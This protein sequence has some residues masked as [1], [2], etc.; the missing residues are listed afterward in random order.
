MREL[1]GMDG[2]TRLV[3]D[4]QDIIIDEYEKS[5]GKL[6]FSKFDFAKIEQRLMS[7]QWMRQGGM[8]G[9]VDYKDKLQEAINKELVSGLDKV[10]DGEL[11]KILAGRAA[12]STPKIIGTPVPSND[13]KEFVDFVMKRSRTNGVA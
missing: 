6:N 3:I 9:L 4:E 12:A 7:E 13:V 10:I 5:M 2:I 1:K 8:W 11:D